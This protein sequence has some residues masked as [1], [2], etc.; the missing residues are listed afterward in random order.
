VKKIYFPS[1]V[2]QGWA[3]LSNPV[4]NS[5]GLL[6][7]VLERIKEMNNPLPFPDF[8]GAENSK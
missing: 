3:T 8:L 7:V 1:R 5:T 2:I 4:T 6:Q